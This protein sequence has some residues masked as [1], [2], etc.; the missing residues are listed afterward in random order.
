MAE[1]RYDQ[2]VRRDKDLLPYVY[3][4]LPEREFGDVQFDGEMLFGNGEDG[5]VTISADTSLSEDMYY[6]NLTIDSGKTLNPN[7]W[8]VFVKNTLTLNG[9]LGIKESVTS[10]SA[11]SLSGTVGVGQSVVDGLGGA[12][13]P[14]GYEPGFTFSGSGSVTSSLGIDSSDFYDLRAAVN[15]YQRRGGDFLRV[16]GGA[17]GGTGADGVSGAGAAGS[18]PPNANT[19]GA[20]G[21]KGS[22]GSGGSG[23]AGARGGGV[24]MLSARVISG[25]GGIYSEGGAGVAGTAGSGGTPAPSYTDPASTVHSEGS[26]VTGQFAPTGGSYTVEGSPVAQHGEGGNV[27]TGHSEGGDVVSGHSAQHGEGGNVV[28]GHSAEHGEG[29]DGAAHHHQIVNPAHHNP[30]INFHL[31][32][33]HEGVFVGFEGPDVITEHEASY[34]EGP[35]VVTGH[36][37]QHGE[38]ADVAQHG[39]GSPVVTGHSEGSPVP[40]DNY[41]AGEYFSYEGPD[42]QT[43]EAATVHPGGGGGTGYTGQRGGR[44]GGGVLIV[45]TRDAGTPTY[46]FNTGVNGR[47][48][49]LDTA[50]I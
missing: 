38:G 50:N 3:A 18:W 9:D 44:G 36:T 41:E 47:L 40:M 46:T 7:G 20:P 31:P 39:E 12:G 24:V 10:V 48:I 43:H 34:T 8:R 17:G 22:A 2:D 23:G 15:T 45:V 21:G 5:D 19:V 30:E 25:E 14:D 16:K 27:V 33:F 1:A 37:A 32:A 35:D 29:P 26:P 49:A 6:N 4:A 13:E 42:V 28:S 11:G